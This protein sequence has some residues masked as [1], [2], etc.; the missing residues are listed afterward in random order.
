M[1]THRN[2]GPAF[3]CKQY[4]HGIMPSGH[5]EGLSLRDYFA[6]KAMLGLL[7][8]PEIKG[9]PQRFALLAYEMADAMIKARETP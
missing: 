6:A 5:S 8:I 4:A 2:G 9:T 7:S 1:T 3:P